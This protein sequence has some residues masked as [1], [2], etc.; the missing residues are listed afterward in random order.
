LTE[1]S[2]GRSTG[3]WLT[4]KIAR[5]LIQYGCW[6]VVDEA[7]NLAATNGVSLKTLLSVLRA[8]DAEGVQALRLL[9]VRAAG[10]TVPADYADRAAAL[11]VK[12]LDAAANLGAALGVSTPLAK[13]MKPVMREVYTGHRE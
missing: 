6:A 5:N 11:A 12:D 1:A 13:A 7:A 3:A 8:A 9:D 10:I 2:S 4:T